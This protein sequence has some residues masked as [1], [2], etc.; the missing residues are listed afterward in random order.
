MVYCVRSLRAGV[1]CVS[2]CALCVCVWIIVCVVCM[3]MSFVVCGMHGAR[4]MV[5]VVCYVDGLCCVC[6]VCML[7]V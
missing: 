1:W 5:Y 7:C 3:C 6:G 2:V 4:C